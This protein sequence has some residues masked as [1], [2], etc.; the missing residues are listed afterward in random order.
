MKQSKP[1]GILIPIGGGEDTTGKK[2]VLSRVISECKKESPLICII[3]L[4]TSKPEDAKKKYKEAFKDI[5]HTDVSFMYFDTR[6]E[7]DTEKHTE[8]LKKSDA[9]LFSGGD[10]LKLSSLLGGTRLIQ[11]IKERYFTEPHFVVAG[12]SAGAAAMSDTMIVGGDSQDAMVKG[13]LELTNGLDFIN[14]I[15]I[16]T[17]FTQRGRFGR[18]VQ[19]ITANPGILGLGLGEDTGVV[20][21]NGEELEVTGSGL[22]VVIDGTEITYSD[23]A[24]KDKGDIITVEGV[25]MHMLGPGKRFRIDERKIVQPKK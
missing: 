15:F 5:D 13:E 25:K 3:T 17:H 12:T 23:L 8:L 19:T 20:I 4:A 16:D 10:Q 9:I 18:I 1:K 7:A 6:E 21:Y 11:I 14:S 2:E 22:V 24:D